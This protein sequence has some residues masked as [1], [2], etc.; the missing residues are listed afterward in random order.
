MTRYIEENQSSP[1]DSTT[2]I[3]CGEVIPAQEGRWH[4]SIQREDFDDEYKAYL[5]YDC[6]RAMYKYRKSV[7]YERQFPP[8]FMHRGEWE[9]RMEDPKFEG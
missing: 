5:H 9:I 2:C 1:Q 7:N 6:H 3:W 4:I 8:H